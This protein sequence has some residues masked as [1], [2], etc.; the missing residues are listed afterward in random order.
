MYTLSDTEHAAVGQLNADYR[1]AHFVNKYRENAELYILTDAEGPFLL[2]DQEPDEEGRISTLL[3]V[4]CHPR[5]AEDFAAVADLTG[6][7][8]KGITAQMFKESWVPFLSE[9]NLM[10]AVMPQLQGDFAVMEPN[11][12]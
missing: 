8:P 11:E 6:L 3:P 9:N 2:D 10:L 5:Y 4:W 1:K 7:T 12:L